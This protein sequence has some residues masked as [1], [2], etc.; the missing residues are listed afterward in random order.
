MTASDIKRIAY[1][2]SI[3]ISRAGPYIPELART[4]TDSRPRG[5]DL[6]HRR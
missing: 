6:L 1:I 2:R 3:P 5:Q 4:V